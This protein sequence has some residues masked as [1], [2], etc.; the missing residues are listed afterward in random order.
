VIFF[1][2]S[3]AD[4]PASPQTFNALFQKDFSRNIK[5]LRGP[6][7]SDLLPVTHQKEMGFAKNAFAFA[8]SYWGVRD[9][10]RYRIA[11]A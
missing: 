11:I 8:S 9:A 10:A 7:T 1:P 3:L 4:P 6:T 2:F 5:S